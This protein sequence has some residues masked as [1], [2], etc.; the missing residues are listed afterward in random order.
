MLRIPALLLCVGLAFGLSGI[1]A[2]EEKEAKEVKLTGTVCCAKCELK[3]A[4]KCA[5]VVKAK[6]KDGKEVIYWFDAKGDKKHHDSICTEA[7]EGT[8]TGTVKKDGDKLIVTVTKV[9]FK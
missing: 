4:D 2:A 8:V 6:N 1:A 9:E 7:K 5:T 3:I